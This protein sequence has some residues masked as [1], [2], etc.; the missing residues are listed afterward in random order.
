ME[1]FGITWTNSRESKGS[2]QRRNGWDSSLLFS[3]CN[4]INVIGRPRIS[5]GRHQSV[6]F[7]FLYL[8]ERSAGIKSSRGILEF[9][10]YALKRFKGNAQYR[11]KTR[12][13]SSFLFYSNL[14]RAE[15]DG[16]KTAG[17]NNTDK[18][19]FLRQKVV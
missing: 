13:S 11:I 15:N 16:K 7:R 8:N 18:S 12:T 6:G 14:N 17:L 3:L 4:L 19:S 2:R 1:T 10:F 9:S 5:S